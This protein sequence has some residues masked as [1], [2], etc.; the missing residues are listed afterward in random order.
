MVKIISFTN[1]KGQHKLI[2]AY[3][4]SSYVMKSLVFEKKK[5]TLLRTT[6]KTKLELH[7]VMT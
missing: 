7:K 6:L 5:K 2:L 3:I 1:G 4:S